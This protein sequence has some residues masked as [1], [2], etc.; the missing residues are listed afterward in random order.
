ML[1]FLKPNPV[2][3]LKKQYEAKQQ[4]AFQAQRNGDIRGY[5]LLTEEAEKIDQQIKELENNA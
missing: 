5:S 1:S 4:Q 2:K 3:K